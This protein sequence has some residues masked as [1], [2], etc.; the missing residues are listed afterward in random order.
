[1][2]LAQGHTAGSRLWTPK[3]MCSALRLLPDGLLLPGQLISPLAE[4]TVLA[5]GRHCPVFAQ[6]LSLA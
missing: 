4:S 3:A 1:M 6:A 5:A 2:Q